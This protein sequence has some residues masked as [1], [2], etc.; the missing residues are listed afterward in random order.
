M[1]S[2]FSANQH[3]GSLGNSELPEKI[4][5]FLAYLSGKT[6]YENSCI[7]KNSLELHGL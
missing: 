4:V 7:K 3:G 1:T 2:K 5:L 6:I